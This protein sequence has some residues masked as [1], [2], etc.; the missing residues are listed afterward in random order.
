MTTELREYRPGSHHAADQTLVGYEV[1]GTDGPLGR[2]ERDT[3][4]RLLVDAGAWVPGF[5]VPVPVALVARIDHLELVVHLDCPRAHV[6]ALP[7]PAVVEA[8]GGGRPPRG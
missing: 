5:R 7:P 4:D 8:R 2:V 1:E 6:R 3:G